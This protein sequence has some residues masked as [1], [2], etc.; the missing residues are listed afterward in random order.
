MLRT[1]ARSISF[2]AWGAIA[3][4][5]RCIASH[6]RGNTAAIA[7]AATR[8]VQSSSSVRLKDSKNQHLMSSRARGSAAKIA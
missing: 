7:A 2:R 6:S 1:H 4:R 5:G 8:A 3:A